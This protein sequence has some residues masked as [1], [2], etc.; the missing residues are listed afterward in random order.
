MA[1]FK[2]GDRTR[3]TW[4]LSREIAQTKAREAGVEIEFRQGEAA[5]MPFDH[6][7]FDALGDL[8]AHSNRQNAHH[9]K[10]SLLGR[11]WH[12]FSGWRFLR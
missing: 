3:K 5:D 10:M 8:S 1:K 7:T 11:K 4:Q 6:E 2:S 12:D 9:Y